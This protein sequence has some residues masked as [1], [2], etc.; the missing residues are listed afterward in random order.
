MTQYF[1]TIKASRI[2]PTTSSKR[3]A[4][5]WVGMI[6][7]ILSI[8]RHSYRLGQSSS[9]T[10]RRFNVKVF[11]TQLEQQDGIAAA[12]PRALAIPRA[13]RI[14]RS[15]LPHKCGM[16]F[17]YHV[18]STGGATIENWLMEYTT[19][20]NGTLLHYQHWGRKKER[21][22]D[23]YSVQSTFINGKKDDGI[24]NNGG[25]NE[26]VTNI[27]QNEWRISHCHHSSMHLNITEHYLS[28]WRSAVEDQGCAFIANVMFRDPLSHALSLFKNID[29]TPNAT[30][31]E[32]LNHLYTKSE[33]GQWQT[34]LDYFL[35]NFLDRNPYGVDKDIKVQRALQLLHDH[36]DMVYVGNHD[37]YKKELLSIT[38]WEDKEMKRTNTYNG[39]LKF[40]KEE[41]EE[42]QKLINQ[43]GDT[44]FMYEVSKL[45]TQS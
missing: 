33:M 35:Y 26:F 14:D 8:S 30:R 44:D 4:I 2:P 21:T 28:E 12:I 15:K 45:Y 25:M 41:V 31:D 40:T 27:K 38:G 5:F 11:P 16:V 20:R 13:H 10:L 22:Q 37:A 24:K 43:N 29:I 19:E 32:W 17:F 23:K 39:E 42:V 1:P 3:K 36:F 7:S 18:P 9:N 6:F 34:Q